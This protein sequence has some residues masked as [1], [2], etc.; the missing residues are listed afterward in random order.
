MHNNIIYSRGVAARRVV[1]GGR[2][3]SN[4]RHYARPV[5]RH[6]HIIII[7]TI[8]HRGAKWRRAVSLGGGAS[9]YA[10]SQTTDHKVY[11]SAEVP[12]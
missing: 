1:G 4:T 2:E 11:K 9:V 8:I 10:V 12:I 6:D 7:I 3:L 5:V